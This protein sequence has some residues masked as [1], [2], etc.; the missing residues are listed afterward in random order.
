MMIHIQER[1]QMN[2]AECKYCASLVMSGSIMNVVVAVS[3][4]NR[5]NSRKHSASQNREKLMSASLSISQSVVGSIQRRYNASNIP[6][7]THTAIAALPAKTK[8]SSIGQMEN[9][10]SDAICCLMNM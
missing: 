3:L 5:L 6:A 4:Q 2:A 9:V 10:L 1:V 8:T 7:P